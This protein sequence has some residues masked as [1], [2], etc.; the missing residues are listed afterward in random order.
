MFPDHPIMKIYYLVEILIRN[1]YSIRHTILQKF[2]ILSMLS[3]I[4][5]PASLI[6]ISC[7]AI[8]MLSY[9]WTAS[10]NIT[11]FSWAFNVFNNYNGFATFSTFFFIYNI[12]IVSNII[13]NKFNL[14]MESS[15]K[16]S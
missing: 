12:I 7:D 4:L 6:S 2:L 8:I 16:N 10:T 15:F 11:S 3:I 13:L 14:F 5:Y 1:F 9:S